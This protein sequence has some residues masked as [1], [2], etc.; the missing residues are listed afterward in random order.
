[1]LLAQ[2]LTSG[3]QFFY[4]AL[5][6][7]VFSP[8]VFGAFAATLSLQGLIALVTT[9]GFP[10]YVLKVE[11]F[12][13]RSALKMR[14]FAVAGGGA[15]AILFLVVS[16]PWLSLLRAEGGDVFVPFLAVAQGI[17]PIA[18]VEAAILRRQGR[19]QHDAL[20]LLG[21]FLI[22]NGIGATVITLTGVQWSLAL[23]T[24]LYPAAL[25]SFFRL[26]NRRQVFD[27]HDTSV[28]G[29]F[30]FSRKI[31]IQNSLFL[32]LQQA[33]S[34]LMSARTGAESLGYFSRAATLAGMPATAMS[35]AI[36][37]ALQPHWRK[38][39]GHDG[40]DRAIR[41]SAVLASALSFSFFGL[42]VAHAPAIIFL[43]LGPGWS[44][45]ADFA[46]LLAVAYAL[47]IPFAVVAN[48]AEMRG[49]FK[50]VRV[51][52]A[53]MALGLAPC[54]IAL[55]LSG[56]PLWAGVGMAVSQVCGLAALIIGMPWK[57]K[58]SMA[59]TLQGIVKQI[60]WAGGTSG[61]G[62]LVSVA[63]ASTKVEVLG[64]HEA[65][66]FLLGASTSLITWLLVFRWN[67]AKSIL[68]GRRLASAVPATASKHAE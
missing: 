45:S 6:A 58:S 15:A 54:L 49:I 5:T 18:A 19:S 57:R 27:Q 42:L 13:G 68:V 55:Y 66:P 65:A 21:A 63:V 22:A 28:D 44:Q 64:S 39:N 25:Y 7:R 47:S 29:L 23:A 62:W 17:A 34:W 35:T 48:S 1:M 26:M 32:V 3:G 24:V 9:T 36:N 37:R 20:C 60:F 51:A 56:Q 41:E 10:A 52:Q 33:P 40:A 46:R 67:E 12:S 43:W 59:S 14:W 4:A 2:L 50:P 8:A 16:G 31:T 30:A 53:A 11:S 38:L 61:T